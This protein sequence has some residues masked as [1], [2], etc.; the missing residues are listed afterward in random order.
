VLS[1]PLNFVVLLSQYV[2][3]VTSTW[4]ET[5]KPHIFRF[6]DMPQELCAMLDFLFLIAISQL[7]W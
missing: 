7:D 1:A 4:V 3:L 5:E 6:D 2:S